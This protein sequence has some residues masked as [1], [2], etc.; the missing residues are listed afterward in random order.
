MKIKKNKSNFIK[1]CKNVR[2]KILEML[3]RAGSGHAGSSM[4][5][6][7][8]CVY[9]Y[10][11][12]IRYKKN[13]RLDK[14]IL[15]KGHAAPALYAVLHELG[16]S[17][18]N[19]NTL[20]KI[21]SPFQGHPDL[22]YLPEVDFSSGALGQGLSIACGFSL[23]SKLSKKNINIYCILGDGELQE[24]Q[25]WESAMFIG[26][27]KLKNICTI[28]DE[29]KFQNELSTLETLD[30]GNIREKFKS[31]GFKTIEIN[32]HDYSQLKKAFNY[33]SKNKKNKPL[34]I[35]LKTIKGKGIS[36]M[37]NKGE[38]H[39]KLIDEKHYQKAKKELLK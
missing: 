26:S 29:N 36:F 2:L 10:L 19:I 39:S 30:L 23:A 18:K 5:I 35:I 32:G 38:W 3:Y 12:Q 16:L 21:N 27:K 8:A 15:S 9:L 13:K 4:S 33:F 11:F 31:F 28:I 7:E 6:V 22:N 1:I 24:G 34:C 20:R 37:E 25:I 17:K 14:F